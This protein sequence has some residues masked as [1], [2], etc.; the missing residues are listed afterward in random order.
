MLALRIK[1]P[2]SPPYYY[3]FLNFMFQDLKNENFTDCPGPLPV[4]D[5]LEIL[6]Y[7]VSELVRRT[8]SLLTVLR[9]EA[10]S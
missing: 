4:G 6:G 1:L 10:L 8:L 2:V 3:F 9:R 7:T 5:G